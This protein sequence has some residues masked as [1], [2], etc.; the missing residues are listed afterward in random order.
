MS[1]VNEDAIIDAVQQ[2]KQAILDNNYNDDIF[3]EHQALDR[4]IDIIKSR[5][6]IDTIALTRRIR[7]SE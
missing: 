1:L 5:V 4:A 7:E 3:T 2:E 6:W